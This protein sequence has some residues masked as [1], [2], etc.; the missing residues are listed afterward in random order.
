MVTIQLIPA[1]HR[2]PGAPPPSWAVME[3]RFRTTQA[4]TRLTA[5]VAQLDR[6]AG[7]D[8]LA[9]VVQAAWRR[10]RQDLHD[11]LTSLQTL[12]QA[13]DDVDEL[14]PVA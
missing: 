9:P 8:E 14:P 6:L 13:L 5:L 1:P 3:A 4:E 11:G 10:A 12:R 7:A 2:H